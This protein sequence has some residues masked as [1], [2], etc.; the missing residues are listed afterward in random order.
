MYISGLTKN[1]QSYVFIFVHYLYTY[2]LHSYYHLDPSAS[3]RVTGKGYALL[4]MTLLAR[5]YE[6]FY[7]Y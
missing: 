2:H 1:Y 5:L 7:I 3:L 4:R 6:K